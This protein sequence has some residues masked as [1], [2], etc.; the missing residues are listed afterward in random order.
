MCDGKQREV[1]EGAIVGYRPVLDAEV[2][3]KRDRADKRQGLQ[4]IAHSS[5]K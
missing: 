1:A 5:N 2:L 4:F 3:L